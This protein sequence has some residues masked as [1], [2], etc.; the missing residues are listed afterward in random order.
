MTGSCLISCIADVRARHLLT[1]VTSLRTGRSG[2]ISP[3]RGE[4][5]GPK[6]PAN[7]ERRCEGESDSL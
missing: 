2:S 1:N 3:M 7:G 6:G 5:R 4:G